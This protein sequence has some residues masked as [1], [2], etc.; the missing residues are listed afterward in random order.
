MMLYNRSP[1][2]MGAQLPSSQSSDLECSMAQ[3]MVKQPWVLNY[4]A[5][6]KATLIFGLLVGLSVCTMV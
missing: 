5:A 4:S 2:S 6:G 3:Q 1:G